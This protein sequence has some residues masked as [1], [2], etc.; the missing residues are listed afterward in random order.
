MA[1]SKAVASGTKGVAANSKMDLLGVLNAMYRD[2][3]KTSADGRRKTGREQIEEAAGSLRMK[4]E[5]SKSNQPE[6]LGE[7][8]C[9]ISTCSV[10]GRGRAQ[11]SIRVD[12]TKRNFRPWHIVWIDKYGEAPS[13]LQYSHRCHE[14][15]CIEPTHGV[16][17]SDPLNKA[18]WACGRCSHLIL[19]DGTSV[20]ICD[21]SPHC[22]RPFVVK[23]WD[24]S[25][26]GQAMTRADSPEF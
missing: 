18:R 6:L 12:G 10:D 22:L 7:Q 17:E 25:R 2:T 21:H 1:E 9:R 19:P 24:D 14:E 16:W 3:L 26:F 23:D 11:R 5:E 4:A 15:N 20:R 8:P 13:G